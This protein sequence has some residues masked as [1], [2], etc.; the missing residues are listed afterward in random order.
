[1]PMGGRVPRM[2]EFYES[3]KKAPE[4]P[5]ESSSSSAIQE[6]IKGASK[7]KGVKQKKTGKGK[8][9]EPK[10]KSK[11]LKVVYI[12]REE[13][14]GYLSQPLVDE[15]SKVV[16]VAASVPCIAQPVFE[17][18]ASVQ[19]NYAKRV[20]EWFKDEPS[21]FNEGTYSVLSPQQRR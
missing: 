7:K 13:S 2:I 14:N 10:G 18:V 16:A 20:L 5:P 6:K 3:C 4:Q 12:E 11:K 8:G 17:R 15:Q 19:L 1:M 21:Y 9:T